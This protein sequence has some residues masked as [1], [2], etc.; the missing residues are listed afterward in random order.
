MA[1]ILLVGCA[2]LLGGMLAPAASAAG[3]SS[4]V[5]AAPTINGAV[6]AA[7]SSASSAGDDWCG[8]GNNNWKSWWIPDH[9][10]KAD[11]HG[12]CLLHDRC[13]SSISGWDRLTCDNFLKNNMRIDCRDAYKAGLKREACYAVANRYYKEVRKHAKANYAG[14]GSSA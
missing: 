7:A 4:A 3:P 12:S 8:P 9:W 1:V 11:F 10:G 5:A 6:V 13:Y 14:S 2:L